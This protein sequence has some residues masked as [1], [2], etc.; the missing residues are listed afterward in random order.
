MP[1]PDI[2]RVRYKKNP[3]I[4]VICQLRYPPILRIDSEVPSAFQDSIREHFPLYNENI[5]L[6]QETAVGIKLQISPEVIKQLTKTGN[7]KSYEFSTADGVCRINLTRTFMSIFTSQYNK[8]EDFI[9]MFQP[10]IEA[11]LKIYKPPFF[12]RIGLR[13]VDIFDRSKLGISDSNWNELLKP[14]FI[15]LLSTE[16]GNDIKHSENIYEINLPDNISIV[17]IATS[18]VKNKNTKE[19]CYLV[20]SDFYFPSRINN[21]DIT[22]KLD[23]LHGEASKLIQWIITPKLHN[24]MEPESI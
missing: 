18:F 14:Q 21:E 9:M 12:T 1:F 8:W 4:K 13:Y 5:E 16:I 7:I 3:L 10:S 23:F 17:R 15:G 19:Q 20:D 24:A 2:K 22:S 6:Q 11:L